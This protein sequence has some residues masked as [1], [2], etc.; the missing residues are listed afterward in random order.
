MTQITEQNDNIVVSAADEARAKD[1]EGMFKAGVH[2]GYSRSRRHPKMA[3]YIFGIR[4]NMEVFDLAKVKEKL[5][6]ASEFMKQ[7]GGGRKTIVFVGT[8]SDIA[9]IVARMAQE[10]GMP[11]AKERWIGG[12]ISNFQNIRKRIDHLEDLRQKQA[13]GEFAKYT[14]KERLELEREIARLDRNFGGLTTLTKIPDAMIVI[15]PKMEIIAVKEAQG[16]K[17]PIVGIISSDS[18]P[19]L[20]GHP[21]PANDSSRTSVEYLLT[22]LTIAYKEGLV[23]AAASSASTATV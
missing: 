8:K 11:Y 14:K 9:D 23:A 13:A 5:E 12:L 18:D 2:F 10:I 17:I 21:I 6:A 1:L 22:Q 3:P 20:V 16:K 15:D 19:E 7:L 4:N